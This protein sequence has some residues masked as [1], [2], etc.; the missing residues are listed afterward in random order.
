MNKTNIFTTNIMNT[1][2]LMVNIPRYGI[3]P[4]QLINCFNTTNSKQILQTLLGQRMELNGLHFVHYLYIKTINNTKQHQQI[5]IA[6]T[7][8]LW[9]L[10]KENKNILLSDN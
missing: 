9:R 7:Y 5:T 6:P 1:Q 2:H 3:I 10:Y 8:E 4:N